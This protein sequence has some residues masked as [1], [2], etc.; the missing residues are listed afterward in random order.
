LRSVRQFASLSFDVS[1]YEM[2][3]AWCCGGTLFVAPQNLR[4][5][6]SELL[7][8]VAETSIEK[9]ILPVGVLKR[10]S[11]DH[12]TQPSLFQHLRDIITTGEQLQITS[13]IIDLFKRLT[14]CSLHNHYGPSE[15]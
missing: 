8:L 7:Q 12:G 2:F 14:N 13:G 3:A 9:V 1:F 11:E 10:W 6:V 4:L 5:D 15:S